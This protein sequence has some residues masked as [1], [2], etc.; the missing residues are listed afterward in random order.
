MGLWGWVL[1]R[2]CVGGTASVS[3]AVRSGCPMPGGRQDIQQLL[4][5]SIAVG[6]GDE[7]ADDSV[8]AVARTWHSVLKRCTCASC[9][10]DRTHPHS[11][12]PQYAAFF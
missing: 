7:G 1:S 12:S 2:G 10:R 11:F 8:A 6:W 3:H 5:C 9:K 4:C